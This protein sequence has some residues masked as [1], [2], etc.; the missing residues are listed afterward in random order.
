[1]TTNGKHQKETTARPK[2]QILRDKGAKN[3]KG[4][5]Y[6]GSGITKLKTT[7]GMG[8]G[9]KDYCVFGTPDQICY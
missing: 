7:F 9:C 8:D 1:M 5:V 6:T 4:G 2:D 3:V